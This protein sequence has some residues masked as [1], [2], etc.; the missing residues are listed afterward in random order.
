[1][2]NN[3]LYS[4]CWEDPIIL[5]KALKIVPSDIVLSISSAGDNTLYL[6]SKSP[7]EVIAIDINPEQNF[8]LELKASAIQNLDYKSCLEFLGIFQNKKRID[9]YNKLR[10]SLSK[11]CEKY[12]N[13]HLN[14]IEGGVIHIGKFER[15]LSLFRKFILPISHSK[16]DINKLLSLENLKKQE[17]FYKEKWDT[18]LWRAT[19]R[20]FFSEFALKLLGRDAKFF[21][22]S[23]NE[24][25]AKYYLNKT[26]LGLTKVPIKSN[27]FLY[28]I[29][30]KSYQRDNLPGYLQPDNFKKI[31]K[32]LTKLKIITEDFKNYLF[33]C[34]LKKFNKFNLS[35]IFE[36][37]SQEDYERLIEEIIRISKNNARLCYWNNLVDRFEHRNGKMTYLESEKL[38]KADKIFF[39]R[40]FLVEKVTNT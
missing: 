31:K 9:L 8:L 29:L 12:W 7:K 37:Y 1:M 32:N 6:L 22:Y 39:Y 21:R 15:Y 28:Y 40:R 3:I 20:L 11:Q 14:L 24:S 5:E 16:Q 19:F 4:Q 33:S 13:S 34:K 27:Y 26:K 35:D 25:I 36:V 2:K 18:P 30:K 23:Q 17:K 10:N 38:E